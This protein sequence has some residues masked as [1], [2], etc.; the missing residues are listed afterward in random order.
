MMNPDGKTARDDPTTVARAMAK[1]YRD[2]VEFFR[3]YYEMSISDAVAKTEWKDEPEEA[4]RAFVEKRPVDELSWFD[5]STAAEIDPS[6]SESL[7]E[8]VKREAVEEFLGGHRGAD[9]ID[10]DESPWDRARYLAIRNGFIDDWKPDGA[11]E[12]SLIETLAQCYTLYLQW[13]KRMALQ[14]VYDATRVNNDLKRN[15][16]WEPPRLDAAETIEHVAMMVERF[17][18][19][20]VRTLRSLRD[21]RRY[22]GP[23][24][25]QKA[26]QVNVANQQVNVE[27]G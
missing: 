6:L 12:L 26:G 4:K 25:I 8:K 24:Y 20:Y 3:T 22:S 9:T 17:H 7:W 27:K 23:L 15:H 14:T 18:R 13:M 11:V 16:R 19:L 21:L 1:S 2:M 10:G 5:F